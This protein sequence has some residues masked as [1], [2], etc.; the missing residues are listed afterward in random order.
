MSIRCPAVLENERTIGPA[1]RTIGIDDL[2]AAL[3]AGLSDFWTMPT[4]VGFLILIYPIVG[5]VLARATME[6][7]LLP[8]VYPL[9]AGFAL[10]GPFAAIGLY[11]L[12]RRR[13]EGLD[14]SWRHVFD[15]LRSRSRALAALGM[16]QLSIFGA[17]ITTAHAIYAALFG[18]VVPATIIDLFHLTFSTSAG[19]MLIVIGNGTG[20]LFAAM[21]LTLSVVSF[22]LLLDRNMSASSAMLV[23]VRAVSKNPV[24]MTLWG[25]IVAAALVIGSLPFFIGL[26]VVV[27]ILGHATWHL[28]R[29]VVDPA[30]AS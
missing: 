27:P 11:E 5:L 30:P 9:M 25:M 20:F 12:S 17:W 24:T 26:A 10:L 19:W 6:E 22:P 18:D 16:V 13:E 23:S 29:R 21:A 7:E 1:V 8:L 2:K 14:T 15:V 4:H 28:Y 3:A